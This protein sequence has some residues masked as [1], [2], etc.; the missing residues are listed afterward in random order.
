MSKVSVGS[1]PGKSAG[2]CRCARAWCRSS[3]SY[4]PRS[5]TARQAPAR[6]PRCSTAMPS[7]H[8]LRCARLRST[9]A[10]S[11]LVIGLRIDEASTVARARWSSRWRSKTRVLHHACS[12]SHFRRPWSA[13]LCQRAPTKGSPRSR[14]AERRRAR[15]RSRLAHPPRCSRTA[16]ALLQRPRL[17]SGDRR[18]RP[19]DFGSR[20]PRFAARSVQFEAPLPTPS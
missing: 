18:D 15:L 13:S 1:A 12:S 19:R 11:C 4:V 20:A 7:R 6:G 8:R 3:V 14:E 9:A 5:M 16:L 10:E 17:P 2:R